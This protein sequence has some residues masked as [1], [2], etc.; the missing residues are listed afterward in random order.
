MDKWIYAWIFPAH[1]NPMVF[2][3]CRTDLSLQNKQAM[4]FEFSK[5][6]LVQAYRPY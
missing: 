4:K 6:N 1:I 3:N 2:M 5:K